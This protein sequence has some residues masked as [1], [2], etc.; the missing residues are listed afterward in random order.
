VIAGIIIVE[1][2]IRRES[3]MNT[4]KIPRVAALNVLLL[5]I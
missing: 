3:Q 4:E 2:A 5:A 1:V